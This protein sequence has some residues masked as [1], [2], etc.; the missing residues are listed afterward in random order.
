MNLKI[1]RD[2][3][4]EVYSTTIAFD[5]FGD[6]VL[7]SDQ[8]Q[9]LL[10]DFPIILDY[11]AITF[12]DKYKITNGVISADA[13]GDT[14]TIVPLAKKVPIVEAFTLSFS[15]SANQVLASEIG[16]NLTTKELVAE[17]K[18][19]LFEDKIKTQI[20]ALL[21]AIKAKGDSFDE[22]SPTIVTV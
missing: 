12:S 14:V 15:Y 20:K 5:S 6:T 10:V 21:D 19:I 7:T 22:N 9:K 8:E 2:I 13:T 16:T 4:N 1:T 3:T 18:V 11:G 17:A